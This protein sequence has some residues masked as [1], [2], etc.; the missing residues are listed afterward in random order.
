MRENCFYCIVGAIHFN[1]EESG[2][3]QKGQKRYR[4]SNSLQDIKYYLLVYSSCLNAVAD[5][6]KPMNKL[7]LEVSEA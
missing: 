1:V 4:D 5:G 2:S 6:Q 3:I 7:I